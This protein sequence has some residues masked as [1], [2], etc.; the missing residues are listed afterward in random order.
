MERTKRAIVDRLPFPQ[1]LGRAGKSLPCLGKRR[2]SQREDSGP[3]EDQAKK[4]QKM[5][6]LQK[7]A[8]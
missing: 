4:V 3:E 7:K 6:L 2:A 5:K 8:A 1:Q